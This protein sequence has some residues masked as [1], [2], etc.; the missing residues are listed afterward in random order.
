M[1]SRAFDDEELERRRLAALGSIRQFGDPV[2]R[3]PAREVTEFDDE[4]AAEV[5]WMAQIMVDARGVGLAA[6]QVG[7]LR[8]VLVYRV[9]E[10]GPTRVLVNPRVTRASDETETDQEG[11]L[12]I[13]EVL[14]DVPR[15]VS[16]TVEAK[17][18]DGT[19]LTLEADDYEARVI[20]HEM[21]HLD[22]IL[23]LDRTSKDQRRAALRE[24]R[25]EAT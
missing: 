13:G 4:L 2:L 15:A 17:D 9:A 5:Q 7:A 14:M 19:P 21:D 10:E 1:S 6:P 25:A 3:T 18:V 12:S 20:Q 16:I 11:C 22:G 23:I 24:L 8:R